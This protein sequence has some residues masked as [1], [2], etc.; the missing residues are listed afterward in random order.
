MESSSGHSSFF[1]TLSI[2]LGLIF[3]LVRVFV[4]LNAFYGT[5]GECVSVKAGYDYHYRL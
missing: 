5:S 1:K 4:N 2:L 3:F